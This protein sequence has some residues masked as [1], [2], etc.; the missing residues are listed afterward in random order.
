M[1]MDIFHFA[2]AVFGLVWMLIPLAT[3]LVA[4]R[5]DRKLGRIA[6]SLDR[7]ERSKAG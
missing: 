7:A 5:I 6:A 4:V 1:H 2:L 3:L